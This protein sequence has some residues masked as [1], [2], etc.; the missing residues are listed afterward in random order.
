MFNYRGVAQLGARLVR[1]QEA[2]GSSPLTPTKQTSQKHYAYA[3]FV[4]LHSSKIGTVLTKNSNK[5]STS[6]EIGN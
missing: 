4:F 2:G 5:K 6:F 1:D 3:V